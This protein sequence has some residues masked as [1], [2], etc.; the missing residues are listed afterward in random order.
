MKICMYYKKYVPRE[1]KNRC[2]IVIRTFQIMKLTDGKY[3]K[4]EVIVGAPDR[5]NM[6]HLVLYDTHLS[7]LDDKMTNN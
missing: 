7:Q 6:P 2:A 3:P 5:V 1:V 4:W